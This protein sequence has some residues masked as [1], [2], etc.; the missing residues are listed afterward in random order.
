MKEATKLDLPFDIDDY[1]LTDLIGVGAFSTVYKAYKRSNNI[2]YAVKV[3][4]KKSLNESRDQVN[5]QREV[6][7][8][9]LLQHENVVQ[10]HQFI[11]SGQYYFLVLDY[12][13]GGDLFTYIINHKQ[14]REDQAAQIFYQIVSAVQYVHSRGVAHRDLKPQ[15][16]LITQFPQVK[17]SDFGLCGF[18][19]KDVK[20]DI[21]CGSMYFSAP[22]C[23]KSVPYD[24][25]QADIWSLGVILFLLASKEHP[26]DPTNTKE[27]IS[28]IT[29]ASYTIPKNLSH[30][31]VDL[32]KSILKLKPSERPTC[33]QILQHHWFKLLNK[34]FITQFSLPPVSDEPIESLVSKIERKNLHDEY[35]IISPFVNLPKDLMPK[36]ESVDS[37]FLMSAKLNSGPN[38]TLVKPSL[39]KN[40][41]FQKKPLGRHHSLKP[42]SN[43]IGYQNN[44]A[45][46]LV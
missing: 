38:A 1:C 6:D 25:V 44:K 37:I 26:W 3:V 43:L 20:M 2:E 41:L 29:K 18:I 8:C 5:F 28:K 45:I 21:Y 16:I 19:Q 14:I 13:P 36:S 7:T 30:P 22:E 12:C 24:G 17:L 33:K 32:I 15:N 9:A 11:S 46:T 4:E 40:S 39:M 31:C 42:G 34:R 10:L 27:M 23:L 35:N